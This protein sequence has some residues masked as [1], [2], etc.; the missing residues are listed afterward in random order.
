MTKT[1]TYDI[2]RW[3]M[4]HALQQGADAASISV[5]ESKS[6]NVNVREQKIDTLEEAIQCSL[7]IRLF[8]D[9]KYSSHSTNRLDKKE[10]ARFIEE[11]IAG[12]RY[13]AE[14][15]F[16]SLPD[17]DLYY[18]GG[19][20]D[21]QLQDSSYDRL[22]PARKVEL[23]FGVEKEAYQKDDR[24]I[25][26]EAGYYDYTGNRLL[27]NSNGFEGETGNSSFGLS[28]SVSVK[29]GEARPS[30]YWS[31]RSIF[32]DQLKKSDI[33]SQAL[34]RALK[35]IGQEKIASGKYDMIVENRIAGRLLSPLIEAL[36]GYNLHQKNSFLI[37]K[38]NQQA[39]SAL[40][41]LTDDPLIQGG[42]GSGLFDDEGLAAQK[43]TIFD[44][45]VLK[46][47]YI[48]TYYGKKLDIPPTTGGTSNLILSQ[49]SHSPEALIASVKKGILVTGFNGGNANGSTGDY[50]F[51]IDGFLIEKGEIIKPVSE[52]NISGNMNTLWNEL[53]AVGNDPNPNS[54]WLIPTLMFTQVDFS[55]L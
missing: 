23:A 2:A 27:L 48:D 35:K 20:P 6:S 46:N 24:I 28:A 7:N 50:S 22:D 45:G 21:L 29:G 5:A 43:R 18:R 49:G 51:G 36:N 9:K 42:M 41:D 3:A 30:D 34:E 39:G 44:K 37:G 53:V 13:L 16:R 10:L 26:V 19:G 25:S 54:S 4:N 31:E 14:D 32:F 40:L 15:S 47:Y 33:A 11:A 38:M 17:P 1:E 12:T 52:M 55:G 8:V